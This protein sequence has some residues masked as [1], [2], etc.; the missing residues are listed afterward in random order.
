MN[1]DEDAGTQDTGKGD[2]F[3]VDGQVW[4]RVCQLGANPAAAYLVLAR[5]TGR[6]NRTSSWSVNALERYTGLSRLRAGDTLRQLQTAGFVVTARGGTHPR[7]HL[8]SATEL[9][10]T[11][12]T[13]TDYART[14]VIDKVKLGEQPSRRRRA[15]TN[16]ADQ[17]VTAGW[18]VKREGRYEL[19]PPQS[20]APAWVWLPNVLVDGIAGHPSAVELVRQT[21]DALTVRLLVDCYSEH[22]LVE[23]GGISRTFVHQ[24]H[25]RVRVGQQG[26]YV[27][28]GFHPGRTRVIW[29]GFTAPH[30]R[31]PT[32]DELKADPSAKAGV[33]FFRRF[34][35]L[36]HVGLVAWVPHLVE[37][38]APDAQP[39]HPAG[40]GPT[41]PESTLDDA[42]GHAAHQAGLAMLTPGQ[43]E[44]A[45][46]NNLQLVPVPAHRADVQLGGVARLRH[47]PHTRGTAAWWARLNTEGVWWRDQYLRL[48]AQAQAHQPL[49]PPMQ[50]QGEFK[51]SSKG[52]Q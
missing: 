31:N 25:E 13:P 29:K 45:E 32:P 37:S 18:L 10:D 30:Y 3:A 15:D 8:V 19:A 22:H 46:S 1:D 5:G 43:Q 20:S 2:F 36:E 48:A 33:D 40:Q 27:V 49:N 38:D 16:C 41:T 9:P 21:G 51:G 28:W 6:D 42:I 4:A 11:R 47:R 23:D 12:P 17:L 44:W 50:Y 52:Y 7:Y 14:Y 26:V 24:K 39:I 35:T 34:G